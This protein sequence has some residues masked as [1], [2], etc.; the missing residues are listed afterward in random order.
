MEECGKNVYTIFLTHSQLPAGTEFSS[1]LQSFSFW[2]S[3]SLSDIA[4]TAFMKMLYYIMM[5]YTMS[6]LYKI[7]VD[8]TITNFL[9]CIRNG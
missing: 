9:K 1:A 5:S 7:L 4:S 2:F 6:I 3:S 8:T